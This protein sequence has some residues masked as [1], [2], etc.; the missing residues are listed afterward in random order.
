LRTR[1]ITPRIARRGTGTGE[2]LGR[3]PWVLECPLA[4][5]TGYWWLTMRSERCAR[6]F[7]AL[8]ALAATRSY[9]EK[10]ATWDNPRP[11]LRQLPHAPPEK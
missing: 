11:H 2:K 7:T 6:L 4:R 5:L 9:Y 1:R 10:L 3:H 8:L